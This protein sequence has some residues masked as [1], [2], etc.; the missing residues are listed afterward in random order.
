MRNFVG[1]SFKIRRA[2]LDSVFDRL[3]V[4]NDEAELRHFLDDLLKEDLPGKETRAKTSGII[5]SIWGSV[6]PRRLPLRDRAVA[7]MPRI[8]GQ[9]RL[10]LHW[11]MTALA[12]P[13]FRDTTEVVGRLLSL[14]DDF[15][16]AQVQARIVTT[17]GDRVTS[18]RAA[19]YLLNTLVDWEVLRATKAKG[20]FL[21]AR[22]MTSSTL[23]LQLWLIEAL[24]AANTA[25]EIEAQQLLRLPESFPFALGLSVADCRRHEAFDFHRQGLD[26]D[27]VALRK[28][29]SVPQTKPRSKLQRPRVKS[30]DLIL[31]SLFD[32]RSAGGEAS[33]S[34]GWDLTDVPF[35]SSITECSKL[36]Q[37]GRFHACIALSQNV[38]ESAVLRV[39]QVKVRRQKNQ[40]IDVLKALQAL[41][42][43][44]LIGD[45]CK[46][47]IERLWSERHEMPQLHPSADHDHHRLEDAAR[48]SLK[49]V[50]DLAK[51]YFG[52]TE[53]GDLVVPHRPELWMA[54]AQETKVPEGHRES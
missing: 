22:K 42:A 43:R 29:R 54:S 1:I 8:S 21:L 49:L 26:M 53:R 51:V 50:K 10:W 48:T 35:A 30:T 46:N 25:D 12:Y 11:G 14:Q 3:A 9:D 6:P 39:W 27:M 33:F 2:W 13:F 16:T 20:H 31:P 5:L 34:K 18:K 28:M 17:W 41:H 45:E 52:Y 15:T 24:L 40:A 36:L 19:Q 4:T 7:L 38:V 44:S 37:E 32:L 47:E 23:D